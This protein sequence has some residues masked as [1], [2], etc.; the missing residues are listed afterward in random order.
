[1]TIRRAMKI[2]GHVSDRTGISLMRE[3]RRARDRE[4][5]VFIW[6]P[7]TAGTSLH[8]ALD[9]PK[10]K[11]LPLIRY[12][13]P[14][15]GMVTFSHMDYAALVREGHVCGEFD[16]TSYKFAFVRNLYDRAV[17]LFFFLK[18]NRTLA[19]DETFLGFCRM[20]SEEGCEPIGTYNV[21]GLSQ[22]NPQVRWLENI[23]LD[24][25]G[26]FESLEEDCNVIL[27]RFNPKI[28]VLPKLRASRRTA[29][30]QYYCLE[31]KAIVE[32][33]YREDF[34]VFGYGMDLRIS[35]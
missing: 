18:K 29:Y 30:P 5:A 24:F 32:E 14:G 7:K 15:S 3:S 27:R 35:S 25:M 12:R 13:F 31:S 20:L 23:T 33:F 26:R 6:I 4:N 22:C 11:S 34:D 9:A 2:L 1:M 28:Q 19:A 17:S 16:R 21:K 10:L 8:S